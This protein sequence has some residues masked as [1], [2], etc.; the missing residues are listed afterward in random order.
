MN[1]NN[2]ST[3]ST[4]YKILYYLAA[5]G[6]PFI[7]KKVDI[8][9]HN[10]N[11]IHNNINIDFDIIV[12]SYELDD[13][14]NNLIY[15]TIKKNTFINEV[16]IYKLKG[17]LVEL[18]KTNPH[19]A[20]IPNYD[21]ILF[22]L[23]DIKLINMDI[24][25]MIRIKNKYNIQILSPKITGSTHPF[26]TMYKNITINNFLEVYCLLLNPD[27]F[28]IFCSIYTIENKWMWGVDHLFGFYKIR[29]GLVNKFIANHE[30]KKRC[31]T[32]DDA[33]PV[34]LE[35]LKKTPFGSLKDIINKYSPIIEEIN[36]I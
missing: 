16:N 31:Y 30:W 4:K 33:E 10:L 6:N 35:Y 28:S 25:E 22:I 17:V 12:N 21:Y 14:I 20:T 5:I 2:N 24:L 29:A 26:M 9:N 7:E 18:F 3:V 34:M 23:D 1:I 11:Y 13:N 8:L 19:N 36:D 27:D 15:N 32:S